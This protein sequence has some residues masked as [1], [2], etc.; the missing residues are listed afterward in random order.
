MMGR[1][2]LAAL[3]ICAVTVLTGGGAAAQG[4]VSRKSDLQSRLAK[5]ALT[6]FLA[7]GPE[8]SC[9]PGC[10]DW[11]AADGQF[12]E[13]SAARFRVFL[14]RTKVRN[15]P[16]FFNS[17]GGLQEEAMAIGRIM[18]ERRMRA[19]IALT[20]PEICTRKPDDRAVCD[21]A[22]KSGKPLAA[23][24]TSYDANCNS[25]CGIAL[26]G[27]AERWIPPGGGIGI[28][29][30]AYYCFLRSGR[31]V[32]QKG[33]SDLA[34]QCRKF[35]AQG[36]AQLAGYVREMGIAPGFVEAMQK[37]PHSEVRYLTREELNAFGI[38]NGDLAETPWMSKPGAAQVTVKVL[39]E[40]TGSDGG[41][42]MGWLELQCDAGGASSI[43]FVRPAIGGD[44]GAG[45]EV[46]LTAGERRFV[47]SP[48]E[49]STHK[50][51]TEPAAPYL[52]R[53]ILVP[54]PEIAALAIQPAMDLRIT[55]NAGAPEAK[56]QVTRIS[57]AG[58]EERW[59]NVAKSCGK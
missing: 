4:S 25:A 31:I 15:L 42:R 2:A 33:N 56:T 18:R 6:F 40:A 49:M 35:T 38:D 53:R 14:A 58:L 9:G 59:R 32:G 52:R 48:Q 28:H 45:T 7:H 34:A 26:I 47:F 39:L 16:V 20:R 50:N 17:N 43:V 30:P 11:I 51:P 29:S 22:K 5:Q 3:M 21:T 44:E 37:V 8:D 36:A 1:I 54:T 57:N 10:R 19:G 24:W 41:K 27:A 55:P 23:E 12:D 46:T 13:G